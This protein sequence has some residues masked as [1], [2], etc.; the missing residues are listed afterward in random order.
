MKNP[1]FTAFKALQD[2]ERGEYIQDALRLGD[3][4]ERDRRLA[5][6]IAYGTVQN[7]I[8]L[9]DVIDRYVTSPD[10]LKQNIRLLLRTALYQ[11]RFLDRVPDRA[12]VNESVELAKIISNRGAAGL[13]NGVLRAIIRSKEEA[14]SIDKEDEVERLSVRYSFPRE[15]VV[16]FKALLKDDA[17]AFF[18]ST[19]RRAHVTLRPVRCDRDAL[20]KALSEVGYELKDSTVRT[21]AVEVLHPAGLFQTDAFK[22]GLFYVQDASSQSVVDLFSDGED[23][24][25]LDL[26]AA[27]GGKS[28]QMAERFRRVDAY[29]VSAKRLEVM[30]EN[31]ERLGY[32]NISTAVRDGR[33]PLPDKRYDRVL[34]DAPCSG[35]GLLRKKPEMKYRIAPEDLPHLAK[36]QRALLENA[37]RALK[38]D[39]ELVYSTCTVTVEE[40]EGVLAS[41]LADHPECRIAGKGV[42]YWPHRHDSDGFT[43]ARIVRKDTYALDGN[44]AS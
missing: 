20:K 25:A 18:K 9:D 19:F 14:F 2:V 4:S 30:K 43:M 10:K 40:N 17:E 44:D 32:D 12:V 7:Q 36:S 42:R 26:C 13:V 11:M 6:N 27:P 38:E 23:A 5:E 21:E 8:Y 16:Y 22:R 37:Y 33:T 15:W 39:G 31:I 29:D 3:L 34:V 24:E 1:R 41:F 28:F 35:L